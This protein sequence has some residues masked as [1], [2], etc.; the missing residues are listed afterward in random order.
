MRLRAM[1]NTQG[2]WQTMQRRLM[3]IREGHNALDYEDARR[4]V[5]LLLLSSLLSLQVV[6]T[7]G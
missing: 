6:P 7:K 2:R 4:R 5:L 1:N 3:Q